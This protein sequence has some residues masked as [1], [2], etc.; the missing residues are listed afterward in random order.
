MYTLHFGLYFTYKFLNSAKPCRAYVV[1]YLES[2]C[3]FKLEIK[4][5]GSQIIKHKQIHITKLVV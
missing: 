4:F 5:G 1:D 3:L 2:K